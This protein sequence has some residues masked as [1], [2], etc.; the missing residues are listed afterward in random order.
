MSNLSEDNIP[1]PVPV[2]ANV[3]VPGVPVP[4]VGPKPGPWD[5]GPNNR[6]E[7]KQS[8]QC[9]ESNLFEDNKPVP[10]PVPANV[11]PVPG[12]P[13]PSVG[14]KPGPWDKGP[15]N[16]GEEKQSNTTIVPVPSPIPVPGAQVPS[17]GPEPGPWDKEIKPLIKDEW[18]K[19]RRQSQRR[20]SNLSEDEFENNDERIARGKAAK[21][22]KKR[23]KAVEWVMKLEFDEEFPFVGSD[24]DL[25]LKRDYIRH[26]M[27]ITKAG[28]ISIYW[29]RFGK[30]QGFS[31]PVK[32]KIVRKNEK[33]LFMEEINPKDHDHTEIREER[34]Y[35][36][37]TNDQVDAMKECIDL[38]LQP[39]N[40]KKSLKK[41]E[42]LT[43][44]S[45][46]KPSSFYHKVN[47]IKKQLSKNQ[48]KITVSEFQKILKENSYFPENADEAFV[49][50]SFVEE[51][52][53][54]LKYCVLISTQ[55]LMERNLCHQDK[56][57]CL[58][59]DATYQ[60]N[61]EGAPVILFGANTFETG[62]KFVGIGAIISS[63]EDKVS[64]NF[65]L[66]FV[67]DESKT[68]PLAVMGDGSSAI[69][70]SCS[71]MLPE[72]RG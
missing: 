36:N 42:L 68:L 29:C 10:V 19:Q 72:P 2:P 35:E 13:V 43:D 9:S 57:W 47:Q 71:A 24:L 16:G 15:N 21:V 54:G 53:D 44:A 60:T 46:P 23:G 37:Y 5:K 22:V 63:N 3:P 66:Q 64:Y 7:E 58:L 17:V 69:S 31:C 67:K 65:L 41:K 51:N 25:K 55:G 59:V 30:K 52:A 40:I 48:V 4:S 11:P 49:V 56:D 6:G 32:V 28:E 70:S 18:R 27:S 33:V 20:E 26:K 45:M 34:V 8:K 12:V 14:P 62:K 38:D 61:M 39:R 50:K 1:V